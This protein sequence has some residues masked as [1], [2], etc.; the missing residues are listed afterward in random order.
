MTFSLCLLL[1]AT[2]IGQLCVAYIYNMVAV[3]NGVAIPSPDFMSGTTTG[4]RSFAA[5]MILNYVGIWLIKLNFLLFFRRLGNHVKTYRILWWVAVGFNLAAGA[6]VIGTMDFR[7]LMP[8]AE[9][10]FASCNN[11]SSSMR[12]Y[13]ISKVSC[14]LDAVCDAISEFIRA[15]TTCRQLLT[16]C[17]K[18][19]HF[20]FVY[21]GAVK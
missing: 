12:S 18:S 16:R 11:P 21:S 13:T 4:L 7:C 20:L 5:L 10:V 15:K 8:P 6:I 17:A 19:S 1:A 9:E 2:I 14:S 3:G